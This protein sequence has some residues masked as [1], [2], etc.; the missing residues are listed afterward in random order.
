ML[1]VVDDADADDA[2]LLDAASSAVAFVRSLL[3]EAVF[4]LSLPAAAASRADVV[5]ALPD[6]VAVFATVGAMPLDLQTVDGA[7]TPVPRHGRRSRERR[8]QLRVGRLARRPHQDVLSRGAPKP[9]RSRTTTGSRARARVSSPRPPPQNLACATRSPI[10]FAPC[11]RGGARAMIGDGFDFA[12]DDCGYP[13]ALR[14]AVR[15]VRAARRARRRVQALVEGAHQVV[16]RAAARGVRGERVPRLELRGVEAAP[17]REA[18]LSEFQLATLSLRRRGRVRLAPR[19]RLDGRQRFDGR[20]RA[21]GNADARVPPPA[22]GRLWRPHGVRRPDEGARARAAARVRR[23]LVGA[24]EGRVRVLGAARAVPDA[25]AVQLLG[26]ARRGGRGGPAGAS[27]WGA[28]AGAAAGF[29]AA[30][31]LLIVGRA[32]RPRP[33]PRLQRRARKPDGHQLRQAVLTTSRRRRRRA[34]LS[35]GGGV[36]VRSAPREG[37]YGGIA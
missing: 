25:D 20:D 34:V 10:E 1:A 24:R 15:S 16:R 33:P 18:E 23:R 4:A 22:R 37:A 13:A 8:R 21:R 7:Q 11:M 3:N 19:R 6:G 14:G 31:A 27:G 26:A 35:G 29:T 32:V 17:A 28:A 12:V 2:A 5:A 36:G 30:F 9:H